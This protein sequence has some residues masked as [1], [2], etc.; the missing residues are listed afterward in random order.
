MAA[1][2]LL[3]LKNK[4]QKAAKYLAIELRH[5]AWK[6]MKRVNKTFNSDCVTRSQSISVC[7]WNNA[8]KSG[9]LFMKLGQ[10]SKYSP[11]TAAR[12]GS[13]EWLTDFFIT[14]TMFYYVLLGLGPMTVSFYRVT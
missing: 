13:L 14:E 7:S 6:Q 11:V 9:L 4:I 1:S 10:W 2:A 5:N 12:L 8:Q 3:T